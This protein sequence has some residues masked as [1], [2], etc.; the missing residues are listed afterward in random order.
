[1]NS[2][3]G[4]NTIAFRQNDGFVETVE[5]MN[6][7][8]A[9]ENSRL[10][11]GGVYLITGGLGGIGLILAEQ[12]A[13]EFHARLVLVSRSSI[14]PEAQW[15]ASLSDPSLSDADKQPIRKL[16]DI[17]SQA[18]GLLVLQG[19]VTN[20]EQMR[21]VVATALSNFGK[22][23][24]VF[25]AAGVLDDAPLMIKER[26]SAERVLSPKIRG[27][28][29]LEAVLRNIP[30]RCFVL[31]SSISSIFPPPGQ[32]DYAAANAF[33]DA[34]ATSR[35]G[36]VTVVNWGAWR[37]VGM[38]AR[39]SS[40]HPLLQ[41]R[42][43]DT[44]QEIV[45][46]SQF[47]QRDQWILSEHKLRVNQQ[48]KALFPGTAYIEMAAAAFS[49]TRKGAIEFRDVFFLAPLMFEGD[50][51][52]TVRVQLQRDMEADS[53]KGAF[54]FSVFSGTSEPTEHSTGIIAP[55]QSL[56]LATINLAS[57]TARCNHGTISFDEQHLTRQERHLTF[58]P[59]WQSLRR[60]LIGRGEALA[61]IELDAKFL[62]DVTAFRMHPALLDLATGSS[63]YLTDKYEDSDD[64]FLPISY[65][66]LRLYHPLPARL[67]SHIQSR[68]GSP[69]LGEVETFD[70]ILFDEQGKVLA[71][72]EGFAAR[73][74]AKPEGSLK[75]DKL[76]RDFARA[77]G[78]QPINI[79]ARHGIDPVAGVQALFRILST[80]APRS[81]IAVAEPLTEELGHPSYVSSP[82]AIALPGNAAHA[83]ESVER[84]LAAWWQEMLG[85]DHVGLDDDFFN[86][87]GH[88][89]IGVRLLA[90]IKRAYRVDL[91]LAALFEERTIRE[92]AGLIHK[93]Q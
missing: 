45:Y 68:A 17:N 8:S 60:L 76:P 79:T 90:K 62:A 36:P 50:E 2:P 12:L 56:P 10:E 91:D 48:F 86:L 54:S 49:K 83:G 61:E 57:I 42:L 81:L 16:M 27:T 65:K 26:Q 3:L 21:N 46:V 22:I 70:I 74:I 11:P 34:F 59:R 28:L 82:H 7:A 87:G 23:D 40:S 1:M 43:V 41:G 39:T 5:S 64:L 15:K 9:S 77:G 92:L 4:N 37:D 53:Q 88:S 31:F 51:T 32:V 25:H 33:L 69:H 85:V 80:N 6:L 55:C 47:S 93:L 58:G 89:L 29:V 78:A 75:E 18:G 20:L 73:R 38:A 52:K 24:G 66:T 67:F 19:D 35:K 13:H 84:T 63:F 14:R 30:L 44:L 71:E 72:I